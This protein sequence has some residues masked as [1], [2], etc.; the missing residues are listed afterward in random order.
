MLQGLLSTLK[1]SV[2]HTK[3]WRVN[4][5]RYCTV[6][7]RSLVPFYSPSINMN[8]DRTS[9]AYSILLHN[10]STVIFVVYQQKKKSVILETF[11]DIFKIWGDGP[12]V[13]TDCTA[14]TPQFTS[15]PAIHNDPLIH[16]KSNDCHLLYYVPMKSYCT[17]KKSCP[18]LHRQS[19]YKMGMG[20]NVL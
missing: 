18:V 17:S 2:K 7:S 13:C 8:I 1:E 16:I 12:A 19:L 15:Y 10:T 20:N 11:F 4:A 5:N 14:I 6:C 9:L 3:Q